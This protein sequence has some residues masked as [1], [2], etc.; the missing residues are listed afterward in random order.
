MLFEWI[1][2]KKC[3]MQLVFKETNNLFW[4]EVNLVNNMSFSWEFV[5]SLLEIWIIL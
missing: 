3:Y 1:E 4:F 2:N 5:R